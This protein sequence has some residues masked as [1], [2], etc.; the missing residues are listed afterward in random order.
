MK[1]IIF[2]VTIAIVTTFS[3]AFSMEQ[4]VSNPALLLPDQVDGWKSSQKDGIYGRDNLYDYINGGAEL[5]LSYGFKKCTNRTYLRPEQPDIVVDLFD[6]GASQNAY[7]VFSHSMETVEDVYGQGSQYSEGLLLFWKD[8]YYVSIMSY[9]ETT[10]SKNALLTLGKEIE[11]AIR[12]EGPLPDV[13]NLLPQESLI[14]ESVRYFRHYAWLNSHYFIADS[15]ILNINDSTDA[16]LA[17]Y[18]DGES[19]ILL[20]LLEY[21]NAQEAQTAHDKFVKHYLPELTRKQVVRIEDGTWTSC[22]LQESLVIIVLNATEEG[23]ALQ[24]M[25]EVDTKRLQQQGGKHGR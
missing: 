15:N 24:L 9:P 11:T 22:Q 18:R 14:R 4:G 8:R 3:G 17:K 16:L 25:K 23:K 2:L 10:E 13:L 19:K 20:L 5:Y 7:G 1:Y 12:G 21:K 6:M